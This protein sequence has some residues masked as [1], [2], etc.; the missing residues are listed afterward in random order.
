[1]TAKSLH[2]PRV[3]PR[4]AR[5]ALGALLVL[6]LAACQGERKPERAA[7]SAPAP[8]RAVD[9]AHSHAHAAPHG[10]LLVEIGDHFASLEVVAD[11][12]LGK[13]TV[14]VYDG[15]AEHTIRLAQPQIA[16]T[17][18]LPPADGEPAGRAIVVAL[19]AVA[20]PLTGETVG[21]TSEFAAEVPQLVGQERFA[22]VVGDLEIRGVLVTGVEFTY[23][24]GDAGAD[25]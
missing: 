7:D 3:T 18:V 9:H 22:A 23:P 24:D 10:G 6:A 25:G 19:D 20:N 12:Q 11:L 17:L 8:Q 5:I 13:L 1:M 4:A 16:M 15:C 21:D 14:Y 2:G